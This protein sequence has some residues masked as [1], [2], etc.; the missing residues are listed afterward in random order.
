ML[1][2][3]ECLGIL[4]GSGW[5]MMLPLAS[6]APETNLNPSFQI[7]WGKK[8]LPSSPNRTVSKTY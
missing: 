8:V 3:Y 2:R 5:L 1:E 4:E 6:S 7:K